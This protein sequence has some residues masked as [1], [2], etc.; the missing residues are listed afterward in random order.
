VIALA[1]LSGLS[2]TEIGTH[3]GVPLGT[4]KSRARLALQRL[5]LDIGVN[6]VARA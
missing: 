6:E 1:Y 5:A 4:V 2:Q 3:L